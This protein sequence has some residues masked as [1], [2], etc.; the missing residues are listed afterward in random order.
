MNYFVFQM[1]DANGEKYFGAIQ[2]KDH[3]DASRKITEAYSDASIVKLY[4][5]KLEDTDIL[6][7]TEEMYNSFLSD[8]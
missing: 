2:A 8:E 4:I 3:L 1:Q 6:M 7:F 5:D